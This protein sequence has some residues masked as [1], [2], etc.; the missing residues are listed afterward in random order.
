MQHFDPNYVG[1]EGSGIY[2]MNCTAEEAG[3]IIIPVPFEATT[4]YGGGASKG[5]AAFFRRIV[6]P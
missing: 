4:S 6:Q 5:P 1:K 3:V 2:G